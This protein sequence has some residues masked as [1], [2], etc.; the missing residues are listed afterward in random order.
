ML[1]DYYIEAKNIFELDRIRETKIRTDSRPNL[2]P[3]RNFI[4]K[5]LSKCPVNGWVDISE[6][7]RFIKKINRNFLTKLVG[8]IETYNDYERYYSSGNHSWEHIEGRFV[9]IILLEYLS[10]LGIVDL[11][12]EQDCDDYANNYFYSVSYLRLTPL[13]AYILGVI[14]DYQEPEQPEA[15]NS[16]I[17]IQPNYEMIV[18]SGGMQE[19]HVLFLDRFAEKVSEGA[20]NVYKISF[21]AIV[22]ALD[23]GIPVQELIDYFQEYSINPI[24]DNVLLTLKEWDL[25]SKKIRIRTVTILETDDQYLL[26]ELKSYKTIR[27]YIRNELPYV[28][29]IDGKS[30]NKLKREIEKKNQFCQMEQ[31]DK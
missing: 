26:E 21:K 22:S 15:A 17:I 7:L 25:K 19:V 28:I 2:S 27:H 14:D 23:Q 6:L 4:L 13:G 8:D 20:V 18:A 3:A 31:G 12:V 11:M 5:Y 9:Q 29:E 10:A 1:F 16:G 30:A 24:P